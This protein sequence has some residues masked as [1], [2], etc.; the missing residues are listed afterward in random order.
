MPKKIIVNWTEKGTAKELRKALEACADSHPI[1]KNGSEGLSVRFE[2]VEEPGLCE[3]QIDGTTAVVRYDRVAQAMRGVGA[4][5]SGLVKTDKAYREQSGFSM[6]GVML[7]CSR[8]AV[9]TVNHLKL[10]FRRLALLGYDT[11]MLYTE[12]TY[13]LPDEPFFGYGRG[14]YTKSELKTIDREAA[15]L[16]IEVIP[17]IQTLGHLEKILRHSAYKPVLDINGVMLVGEEKTYELIEKMIA[18]WASVCK[19]RRFHIGMDETHGLGRGRYQDLHG[20]RSPFDIF[21]EHLKRVVEICAKYDVKPMIWS[22]MYFRFGNEKHV[23]YAPDAEIPDNVVRAIPREVELVYW[24]YYHS[25]KDMYRRMIARHRSMGYEPLM[26]SGIWTWNRL[27]YD[28]KK[29]TEWAG[30]CIDV[31]IEE[32]LREIFFTMWGDNGAYCDHDSAF[33]G[34]AWCAD[35]IYSGGKEPDAAR[36]EKRFGAVCGGS[37]AAHIEASAISTAVLGLE[38]SNTLW[39]DPFADRGFRNLLNDDL[40]KMSAAAKTYDKLATRLQ[41]HAKDRSTGD[42]RFAYLWARAIAERYG[43]SAGAVAAY[44][45][46]DRK[47]LAK[48]K[49]KVPAAARAWRAAADAFRD[50]WLAHNKPDG[51]EIMQERFGMIDARYKEMQK[52]LSGYL[53]GDADCIPELAA[54]CPPDNKIKNRKGTRK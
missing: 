22:D 49:E 27:W 30:P 3:V 32:G 36:L 9:M 5:L 41:K 35:R 16:G 11:V 8:N 31:C 23:Y 29:T 15:L 33:A 18:H 20:V 45:K 48:V 17:C 28:H 43:V 52:S 2:K 7:D 38:P 44:R 6:L 1:V 34:M 46:G 37:Y 21:N 39:N 26:G 14:A 25:D 12:E 40:S 51:L 13:E 54:P 42:M 53:T 50:M 4:L 24:D 19:T 47:A 10:W